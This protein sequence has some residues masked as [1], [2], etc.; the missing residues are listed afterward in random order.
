MAKLSQVYASRGILGTPEGFPDGADHIVS[1]QPLPN[2]S[3]R[4]G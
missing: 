1:L 2:L 4:L 3:S